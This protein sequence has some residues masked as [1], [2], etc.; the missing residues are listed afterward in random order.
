MQFQQ[1]DP[2]VLAGLPF[3]TGEYVGLGP[4]RIERW[5]PG[6]FV[7]AVTFDQQALCRPKIDR[8]RLVFIADPSTALANLLSG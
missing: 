3:W 1:L 5:E 4:Y 8:M 7:E 2:H 6:A